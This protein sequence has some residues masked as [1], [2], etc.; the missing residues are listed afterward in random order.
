[1]F[2]EIGH[3][4]V[5]HDPVEHRIRYAPDHDQ[6]EEPKDK[7]HGSAADAGRDEDDDCRE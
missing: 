1:M 4:I 5:H 6:D 3:R 2:G 7:P